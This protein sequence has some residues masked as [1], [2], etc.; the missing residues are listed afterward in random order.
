MR[1]SKRRRRT[2]TSTICSGQLVR[3]QNNICPQ[4]RTRECGSQS[5]TEQD[6]TTTKRWKWT[7]TIDSRRWMVT[8]GKRSMTKGILAAATVQKTVQRCMMSIVVDTHSK[9][10]MTLIGL[11]IHNRE[12]RL[13]FQLGNLHWQASLCSEQR[14]WQ[15]ERAYPTPAHFF[16]ADPPSFT[17]CAQLTFYLTVYYLW[18]STFNMGDELQLYPDQP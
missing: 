12:K 7:I 14:N 15:K 10:L 1:E 8:G 5:D 6:K 11:C 3:L 17:L 18:Y 2:L 13:W 16:P 9:Q 4:E